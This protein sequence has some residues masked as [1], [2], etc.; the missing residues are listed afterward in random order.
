ME[1][2]CIFD[3]K[4]IKSTEVKLIEYN[5]RVGEKEDSFIE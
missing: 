3:Y 5:Y 2:K 1:K 4:S